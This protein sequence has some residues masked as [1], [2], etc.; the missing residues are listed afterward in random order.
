MKK[1]KFLKQN[2][3]PDSSESWKETVKYCGFH[4]RGVD[5]AQRARKGKSLTARQILLVE[6]LA[7]EVRLLLSGESV[8]VPAK[9]LNRLPLTT[10]AIFCTECRVVRKGDWIVEGEGRP[11]V[12]GRVHEEE[13]I[14]VLYPN[15]HV[16]V[17]TL[18]SLFTQSEQP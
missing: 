4:P 10:P 13:G 3:S 18:A 9:C 1:T 15:P 7:S 11:G 8:E 2:I 14:A 17:R 16:S 12:I 5:L 6:E